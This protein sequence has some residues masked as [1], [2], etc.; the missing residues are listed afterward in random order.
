M[1]RD[2]MMTE[3][4]LKLVNSM[5]IVYSAPR[6]GGTDWF[7]AFD[8]GLKI[9]NKISFSQRSTPQWFEQQATPCFAPF[10]RQWNL[11]IEI[12]LVTRGVIAATVAREFT[13]IHILAGKSLAALPFLFEHQTTRSAFY[14]QWD[15]KRLEWSHRVLWWPGAWIKVSIVCPF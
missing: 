8:L 15:Q 4:F 2:R 13:D 9:A 12:E 14:P 1:E 5:V 6:E 3:Q 7:W 10:Q 11:Q